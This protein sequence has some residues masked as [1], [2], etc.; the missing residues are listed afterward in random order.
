MHKPKHLALG[1]LVVVAAFGIPW[2]WW[3]AR[4]PPED[5]IVLE[6][7][8][9]GQ[10]VSVVAHAA[11]RLQRLTVA[12]GDCLIQGQVLAEIEDTHQEAASAVR[13]R[14][15]LAEARGRASQA[16]RELASLR[17]E[18]GSAAPDRL[19]VTAASTEPEPPASLPDADVLSGPASPLPPESSGD[20]VGPNQELIQRKEQELAALTVQE[21]QIRSALEAAEV[22]RVALLV[23]APSSCMVVGVTAA[24]DDSLPRDAPVADIVPLETIV[25]KAFLPPS[26]RDR[27]RVGL[28]ARVTI[29]GEADQTLA[30]AVG[31][32]AA[33][34]QSVPAG[35][36]TDVLKQG[37]PG[38]A[39][40]LTFA[41]SPRLCL[42]PGLRAR[43]VIRLG[44][45]ERH[46]AV[47]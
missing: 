24:V 20:Q 28:P 26:L 10:P 14:Q 4:H 23:T 35:E 13:A 44:S 3:Q 11:G 21:R 27:L 33:G 22:S 30:A 31:T 25:F 47:R 37:D 2:L 5:T 32:L 34:A 19:A 8:I 9:T 29:A 46:A 38:Y 6:G 1:I 7:R 43:A 18:V 12:A 39:V 45:P 41:D 15:A 36:E 40:T 16:S 42:R 17:G